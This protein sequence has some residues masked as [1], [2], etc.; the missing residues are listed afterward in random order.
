MKY[1]GIFRSFF[2]MLGIVFLTFGVVSCKAASF[3]PP[4][5]AEIKQTVETFMTEVYGKNNGG[6]VFK[7]ISF[8]FD[9]IEIGQIMTGQMGVGGPAREFYPVKVP[10]L[11]TV[12]YSN[13]PTVSTT[14]RGEKTDDVFFFYKDGFNK[15]TFRTGRT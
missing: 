2:V 8:K 11:I 15:W 12:T 4:T 9:T 5:E 3:P 1:H 6:A 10:F 7:D 13:N 14:R